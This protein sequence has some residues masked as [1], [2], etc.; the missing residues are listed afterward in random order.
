MKRAA[1][2]LGIAVAAA[3]VSLQACGTSEEAGRPVDGGGGAL[4]G[5]LPQ[6][7]AGRDAPSSAAP[8][9]ARSGARL[10][11][12]WIE[13]SG[14]GAR[15]FIDWWD[16]KLESPCDVGLAADG[17]LRCLPGEPFSRIYYSDAACKNAVAT[18]SQFP[19]MHERAQFLPC[20]EGA[21]VYQVGASVTPSGPIYARTVDGCQTTTASGLKALT[22]VDPSLLVAFAE[23][24]RS[25]GG[26]LSAGRYEA[27]DGAYQAAPVNNEARDEACITRDFGGDPRCAPDLTINGAPYFDDPGCKSPIGT[28]TSRC[29]P[30]SFGI[31]VRDPACATETRFFDVGAP[32]PSAPFI[33]SPL[34][35]EALSGPLASARALGPRL[36]PASMP[37]M[38]QSR[39]DEGARIRRVV[40]QAPDGAVLRTASLW[41]ERLGGPC[42]STAIGSKLFCAPPARAAFDGSF[43]DAACTKPLFSEGPGAAFCLPPAV[44]AGGYLNVASKEIRRVVS[45]SEPASVYRKDGA[46]CASIPNEGYRYYEAGPDLLGDLVELVPTQ[47]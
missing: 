45:S 38:K 46:T 9:D 47:D 5:A 21:P 26:G 2:G 19:Y 30:K 42:S 36:L 32:L 25:V 13:A 22:P 23:T 37:V 24:R 10:V 41:D 1:L 4:D 15:L 18:R 11:A 17:K 12:E 31:D 33:R 39:I 35:C 7:D 3:V 43:S 8:L 27:E 14:G 16:T 20:G 28:V 44:P 6:G 34:G 29:T 40:D